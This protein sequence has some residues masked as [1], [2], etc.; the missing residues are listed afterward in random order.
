[1]EPD[2]RQ[3]LGDRAHGAELSVAAVAVLLRLG[4]RLVFLLL[5]LLPHWCVHAG[6]SAAFSSRGDVPRGG[7]RR[8]VS[9]IE[10]AGRER[11]VRVIPGDVRRELARRLLEASKARA[12]G[13]TA[14][15]R[16]ETE[17]QESTNPEDG[18]M[19]APALLVQTT[20]SRVLALCTK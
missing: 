18:L 2:V 20:R 10:G 4:R 14:S 3:G 7:T 11:R 8:R 16:H 15:R 9:R 6:R 1:V 5:L 17:S 19:R 12:R 13:R